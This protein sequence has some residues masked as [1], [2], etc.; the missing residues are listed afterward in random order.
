MACWSRSA[1]VAG[2]LISKEDPFKFT[3]PNW[4]NGYPVDR[5]PEKCPNPT[6][7]IRTTPSG[8]VGIRC[9]VYSWQL[10]VCAW[11]LS[12]LRWIM[13]A[14]VAVSVRRNDTRGEVASYVRLDGVNYDRN[15]WRRRCLRGA[16]HKWT[17]LDH[18]PPPVMTRNDA[19]GVER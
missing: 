8:Q 9:S 19:A 15:A 2:M 16:A 14:C 5:I 11:D 18:G 6:S 17:L 12:T 7:E 10:V 3:L 4:H 1:Y 13:H